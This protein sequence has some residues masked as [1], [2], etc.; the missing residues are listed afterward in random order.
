MDPDTHKMNAD[1]QPWV[2]GGGWWGVCGGWWVV[3]GG[4]W[5]VGGGWW[6]V[7]SGWWVMGPYG[8]DWDPGTGSA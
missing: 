2:V 4:W 5:V 7:G 3:G 8:H 1:P 6:E